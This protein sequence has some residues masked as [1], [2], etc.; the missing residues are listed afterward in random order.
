MISL[1][2]QVAVAAESGRLFLNNVMN[3]SSVID[4]G[5]N[6]NTWSEIED[7]SKSIY[8]YGKNVIDM[9]IYILMCFQ[10]NLFRTFLTNLY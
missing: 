3:L 1:Y 5:S 7:Y 9:D 8:R 6:S 2:V 10:S 4:I